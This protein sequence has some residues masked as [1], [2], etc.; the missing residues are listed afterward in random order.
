MQRVI[1]LIMYD[2]EKYCSVLTEK[3]CVSGNCTLAQMFFAHRFKMIFSRKKCA[4]YLAVLNFCI[5]TH[6]HTHITPYLPVYCRFVHRF[7]AFILI[8]GVRLERFFFLFFLFFSIR[9]DFFFGFSFFRFLLHIR[10]G[11]DLSCFSASNDE[12][13]TFCHIT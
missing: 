4:D 7:I 11:D 5:N 2:C 13:K 8:I 1:V 9:R 12:R 10:K 6:T 3:S